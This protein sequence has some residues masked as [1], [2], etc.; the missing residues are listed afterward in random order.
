M[1]MQGH[2]D[3]ADPS[4]PI[5]HV[6]D[7]VY[8]SGW[9][10]TKYEGLMLRVGLTHILKMYES[11]PY[12]SAAFNTLEN[13]CHD[14]EPLPDGI[15]DRSVGF[16]KAQIETDQP[17]LVMCGAGISRSSTMVLAYLIDRGYDLRDA[18]RLL[19]TVHPDAAPHPVMWQSL[20]SHY[21]LNYSFQ[22][23]LGW[24]YDLDFFGDSANIKR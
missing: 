24:N 17:V 5:D 7:G 12:F 15:L 2:P 22:D 21:H 4:I 13:A 18:F 10:A 11:V 6:I 8:I 14:G 19:R 16:I 20:I 3:L 23:A 1:R 9:R